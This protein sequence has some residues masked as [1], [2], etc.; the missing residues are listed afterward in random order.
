MQMTMTSSVRL[1]ASHSRLLRHGGAGVERLAEDGSASQGVSRL[2]SLPVREALSAASFARGG[3]THA[4]SP[5]YPVEVR[6]PVRRSDAG[7]RSA[8][9]TPA[10]ARFPARVDVAASPL[11][12]ACLPNV[13]RPPAGVAKLVDGRLQHDETEEAST[14]RSANAVSTASGCRARSRHPTSCTVASVSMARP[15]QGR[16]IPP[17]SS[18]EPAA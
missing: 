7:S 6:R 12:A 14:S 15:R 11:T 5:G 8:C 13:R 16:T 18:R 10:P 9:R 2:P 17:A 4:L 3:G 1:F